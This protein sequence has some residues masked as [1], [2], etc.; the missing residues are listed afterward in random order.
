MVN[1]LRA[2]LFKTTHRR[3]T[4]ILLGAL[5]ALVALFYVVLW[6][7]IR[8][9]PDPGPNAYLRWLALREGMSF[10]NVVPYGLQLERFF[11]TLVCVTFAATMMGN[12]YDWRT[13]GVVVS[14]GVKR[15]HFLA[16]KVTVSVL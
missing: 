13:A 5:L 2:E 3:M 12:E 7:R 6:L 15:H 9:G 14:R 4:Y 11:A 16:A 1:A 10:R 8:Q